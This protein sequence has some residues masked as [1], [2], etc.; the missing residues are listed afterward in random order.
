M[1]FRMDAKDLTVFQ[2]LEQK[3]RHHDDYYEI[4][5]YKRLFKLPDQHKNLVYLYHYV[6]YGQIIIAMISD[7]A[8]IQLTVSVDQV[9]LEWTDA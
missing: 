5:K 4:K 6:A 9:T 3:Y 8:S 2:L 1:R 7:R